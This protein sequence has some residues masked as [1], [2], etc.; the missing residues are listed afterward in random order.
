MTTTKTTQEIVEDSVIESK[1]GWDFRIGT[2]LKTK[3]L[4]VCDIQKVLDEAEHWLRILPPY[5]QKGYKKELQSRLGLLEEEKENLNLDNSDSSVKA[6]TSS[7]S[8]KKY[9]SCDKPIGQF[10]GK[11][12]CT[13]KD[14]S[15]KK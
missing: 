3:W 12:Q 14:S 5:A 15:P 6:I 4:L 2:D 1:I 9:K 10:C 13:H 8:P 7:S 11:H